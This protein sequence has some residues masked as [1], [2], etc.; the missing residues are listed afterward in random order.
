M[1]IETSSGRY[2]F[3]VEGN[4]SKEKTA[5]VLQAG[6]ANIIYRGIFPAVRKITGATGKLEDQT[7]NGALG[8]KAQAAIETELA[9]LGEFS[10]VTSEYVPSEGG[11]G[12]PSKGDIEASKLNVSDDAR[13]T[14]FEAA[15]ES[16][17]M[18]VPDRNSD[19]EVVAMARRNLRLAVDK[20]NE[21]KRG[22]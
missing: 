17:D 14:K 11:S 22:F 6:V 3:V 1:K 10:V 20:E 4:V 2:A 13:W 5:D 19:I 16:R 7:F 21:E 12:K 8:A 9:K 18:E 15:L